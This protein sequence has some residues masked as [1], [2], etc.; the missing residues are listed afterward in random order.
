MT[1]DTQS[2]YLNPAQFFQQTIIPV[3]Q[4]ESIVPP[5]YC[6]LNQ[7]NNENTMSNSDSIKQGP[8]PFK[9][10]GCN[11]IIFEQ[12]EQK[13]IQSCQFSTVKCPYCLVQGI[14]ATFDGHFAV[15]QQLPCQC[16]LCY[17]NI[18]I[19]KI[20]EHVQQLHPICTFCNIRKQSVD[21]IYHQQHKCIVPNCDVL[22]SDCTLKSH[23]QDCKYGYIHTAY[24]VQRK[25]Q[26]MQFLQ[27]KQNES[28][29]IESEIQALEKDLSLSKD[30]QNKMK[31]TQLQR[32]RIKAVEQ[33]TSFNLL[34]ISNI[35]NPIERVNIT[36]ELL[37]QAINFNQQEQETYLSPNNISCDQ[38]M[39]IEIQL[40]T[41]LQFEYDI[42]EIKNIYEP[43]MNQMS[44]LSNVNKLMLSFAIILKHYL[45]ENIDRVVS[46]IELSIHKIFEQFYDQIM[47]MLERNMEFKTTFLLIFEVIFD[48]FIN[49]QSQQLKK[50]NINVEMLKFFAFN[51]QNINELNLLQSAKPV[52]QSLEV[53]SEL[54]QDLDLPI[55]KYTQ[56]DQTLLYFS[57]NSAIVTLNSMERTLLDQYDYIYT[58]SQDQ[59][60]LLGV[61]V[62]LRLNLWASGQFMARVLIIDPTINTKL[63]NCLI[64]QDSVKLHFLSN[65]GFQS[66]IDIEPIIARLNNLQDLKIYSKPTQF[67]ITQN[68]LIQSLPVSLVSFE[69]HNLRFAGAGA[70]LCLNLPQLRN[71]HLNVELCYPSQLQFMQQTITTLKLCLKSSGSRKMLYE[72]DIPLLFKGIRQLQSLEN[73]E[74]DL[75][76]DFNISARGA[77]ELVQ[78]LNSLKR[79][80]TVI[81][82]KTNLQ[83][84]AINQLCSL[85]L[86]ETGKLDLSFNYLGSV[87]TSELRQ[88]LSQK[89]KVLVLNKIRLD[90]EILQKL[91]KDFR[92][93]CQILEIKGNKVNEDDAKLLQKMCSDCVQVNIAGNQL[94]PSPDLK[95]P[96]WLFE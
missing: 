47:F 82:I 83:K 1:A 88:L 22:V 71:L 56:Y 11:E 9:H 27:Q 65:Y 29:R 28:A 12:N 38:N 34:N 20:A 15:C 70:E 96:K 49:L 42:L 6:S 2:I 64:P 74:L 25:K 55:I 63:L 58:K 81:L 26:A 84:E 19:T 73:F 43:Y 62:F 93:K 92:F 7:I 30:I 10:Q 77:L 45:I 50:L 90:N 59:L 76:F 23:L 75:N 91:G 32:D 37:K 87:E 14:R 89:L 21:D 51:Q 5:N 61:K 4:L 66:T 35:I 33:K 31:E 48:D 8:C 69:I 85:Q 86:K 24:L 95:E 54:V 18:Q 79:L 41:K 94:Q 52:V 36:Y 57:S 13:H 3:S 80:E 60:F 67:E 78:S 44:N 17:Q 16:K 53:I 39:K 40:R 68:G 72:A 46:D